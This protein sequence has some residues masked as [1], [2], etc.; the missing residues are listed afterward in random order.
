MSRRF[1]EGTS[2]EANRS[3]AEVEALVDRHGGE[4]F[5]YAKAP[6]QAAVE[7]WLCDRR[8]RFIVPFPPRDSEQFTTTPTG[9]RRKSDAAGDNAHRQEINRR[10]RSLL[11]VLKAKFAAID[12]EIAEFDAEF[13]GKIVDPATGK[14]LGEQLQPL[15]A[16]SYEQV[17]GG[18]RPYAI[19]RLEHRAP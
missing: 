18:D 17:A 7:F 15:V 19:L 6:E 5:M 4:A 12:D 10:W 14:T 11:L 1:A 9:R 2:V 13:M 16:R 8:L 3:I